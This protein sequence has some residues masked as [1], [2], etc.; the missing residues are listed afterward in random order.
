M[1][2][3]AKLMLTFIV[4]TLC[5]IG[6]TQY[7]ALTRT[8]AFQTERIS[9]ELRLVERRFNQKFEDERA[10]N[11]KLVSTITSEQKYRSFLQQIRDNFYIFAEEIALDT[12][13]GIVFITDENLNVRG[14]NTALENIDT[15]KYIA[16]V[17][18]LAES[19]QISDILEEVLDNGHAISKVIVQN[20]MLL[21]TTNVPLK[22]SLADDYALGV[23]TAAG[24]INDEWVLEFLSDKTADID[25][26]YYA[27]D[28][29]VASNVSLERRNILLKA[30]AV[31]TEASENFYLINGERFIM[32]RGTFENTELPAGYFFASSFDVAMEPFLVLQKTII[33]IGLTSLVI[34]LLVVWLLTNRIVFPVRL[35]VRGT[36][37]IAA[38]NYDY[39]VDNDS[40]DEVGELSRAF[41]T[42]AEGLRDKDRIKNLFGRYVPEAVVEGLISDRGALAP[43]EREA[44]VLFA[45][46]AGFTQMTELS[47]PAGI[48]D[49]LNAY[50][51]DATKLIS[52]QSGVVTQFQGDAVM[53]IFNVPLEDPEHVSHAMRAALA[54]QRCVAQKTYSGKAL[55]VRIGINTGMLI[56]G[57]VG[58]G[59]RQCY[60][61]HGDTVNLAARLEAMNKQLGTEILISEASA[62]HLPDFELRSQGMTEVRGLSGKIEIFSPV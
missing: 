52:E 53:A 41:N 11:E 13:A 15:D 30:A 19:P 3:R 10:F 32:E 23:V 58:G 22:E 1:G 33:L 36:Q 25:V 14:I 60:T 26:I 4:I 49:I 38:G 34:G 28:T 7:F 5:L 48:I 18:T 42:M 44:T 9:A 35:L 21:N 39:K 8:S 61:V 54:I 12:G 37:E 47:G 55:K 57:N 20:D 6:F 51:D 40:K 43:L 56:A 27:G 16:L 24:V 2:L 50:F 62:K 31:A 17:E 59:E 45:D 46:L 29:A